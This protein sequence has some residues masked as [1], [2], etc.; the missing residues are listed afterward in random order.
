M[1]IQILYDAKEIEL[2]YVLQKI[3]SRAKQHELDGVS[4]FSNDDIG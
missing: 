1:S 2:T 4:L 3:I